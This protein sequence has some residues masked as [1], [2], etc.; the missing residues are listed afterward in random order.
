ML[1][2][3]FQSES[4]PSE[5]E[6][7]QGVPFKSS[8]PRSRSLT[9]QSTESDTEHESSVSEPRRQESTF[10]E[11][12]DL[13]A[14]PGGSQP[15]SWPDR[16]QLND[17]MR[18]MSI[19]NSNKVM[20]PFFNENLFT[21]YTPSAPPY[22]WSGTL[23]IEVNMTLQIHDGSGLI[24]VAWVYANL[25]HMVC[26]SFTHPE[27][28]GYWSLVVSTVTRCGPNKWCF[29]GKTRWEVCDYCGDLHF[30]TPVNVMKTLRGQGSVHTVSIRGVI[31]TIPNSVEG[32]I[33]GISAVMRI[34][35]NRMRL[36]LLINIKEHYG[37]YIQLL[38]EAD[39]IDFLRVWKRFFERS[40]KGTP[41]LKSKSVHSH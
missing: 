22:K 41:R 29:K 18:L 5:E 28:I 2:R 35:D 25:G 24:T 7:D 14:I 4:S 3:S 6:E 13:E 37:L 12:E 40:S 36:D 39:D 33:G 21:D 8:T 38:S 26:E 1:P 23:T 31:K 20:S 19:N 34:L 32:T 16:S 10:N 30:H 27:L 17:Q 9:E 15:T 11:D